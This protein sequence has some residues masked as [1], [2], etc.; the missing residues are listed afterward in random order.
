MKDN[1]IKEV[2][3]DMGRLRTVIRMFDSLPGRLD[4]HE[5]GHLRAFTWRSS[6][7]SEAV[8]LMP[9]VLARGVATARARG[10]DG[11]ASDALGLTPSAILAEADEFWRRNHA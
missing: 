10:A 5:E 8:L 3:S 9:T 1:L 4:D 7:T 6:Q 2:Q 11:H